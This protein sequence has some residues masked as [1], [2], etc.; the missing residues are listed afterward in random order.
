GFTLLEV[1]VAIGIFSVV[2]MVSYSTLDSYLDQ[3][4]RLTVHYAKFERLQR[5]FLLLERDIQFVA[6]RKVRD[7]GDIKPAIE[8]AQGDVLIAM[9]VAQPDVQS[10]AEISLKR[11]EWQL[12]GNELLRSQWDVLDH[13]GKTRPAQ[14]LVSDEIQDLEL[15]YWLYSPNRGPDSKESLDPDDFPDGVELNITLT[16]GDSYRRVFAIVQGG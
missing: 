10:A 5:L 12:N 16:S 7:G 8:S 9:T 4:E 6:G 11:V 14:L 2:A 13:D 3:R 1:L 15:S